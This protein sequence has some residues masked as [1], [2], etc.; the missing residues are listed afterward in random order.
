MMLKPFLLWLCVVVNV[1][2]FIFL[3]HARLAS[4]KPLVLAASART[5][6]SPSSSHVH[7]Y[8]VDATPHP[9]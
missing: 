1:F 8:I 7:I 6:L 3:A 4:C 5:L 2:F 9:I